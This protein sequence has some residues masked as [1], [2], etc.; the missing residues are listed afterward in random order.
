[1]KE[2]RFPNINTV[3]I[4]GRLTKN[5]EFKHLQNGTALLKIDIAFNRNFMKGDEWQQ[6]TGYVQVTLWGDAA[7]KMSKH[8]SKGSP[9]LVEAYHKMES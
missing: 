9:V 7:E 3:I 4:S 8:I 5:P 1:M 6:E 2:L